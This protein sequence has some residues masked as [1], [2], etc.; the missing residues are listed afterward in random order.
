MWKQRIKN[1][2][3]RYEKRKKKIKQAL[4]NVFVILKKMKI[5]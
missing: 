5:K 1:K 3:E 2:T 4:L